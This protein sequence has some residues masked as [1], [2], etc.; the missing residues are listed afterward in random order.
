MDERMAIAIELTKDV[1][2]AKLLLQ[3]IDMTVNKGGKM[4][5][6]K[7]VLADES[8]AWCQ[9]GGECWVNMPDSVRVCEGT[10][11][12]YWEKATD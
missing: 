11:D 5:N 7:M 1:E 12:S 6:V 8:C 10:C 9:N 2:K 3:L 4:P